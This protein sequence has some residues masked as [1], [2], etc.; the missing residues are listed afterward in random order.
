MQVLSP[1][2]AE[3]FASNRDAL[4]GGVSVTLDFGTVAVDTKAFTITTPCVA[5]ALVLMQPSSSADG[6]ELEMDGL[7]CAAHVSATNTVQAY[8]TAVP[9]PISGPRTFT[10]YFV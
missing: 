5:G 1:L 3:G 9:G 7:L 10:L 8:V 4:R 6:D 2:V